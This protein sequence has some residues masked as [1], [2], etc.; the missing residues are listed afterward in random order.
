MR[1]IFQAAAVIALSTPVSVF[2]A[3]AP[4]APEEE[5]G[6]PLAIIFALIAV[7]CALGSSLIA[8]RNNKKK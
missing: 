8:A 4:A 5:R 3:V 6:F 7:F 1:T 2:A